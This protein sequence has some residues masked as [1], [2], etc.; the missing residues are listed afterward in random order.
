MI[1]RRV[2]H[3]YSNSVVKKIDQGL[4]ATDEKYSYGNVRC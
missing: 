1:T 2:L 3:I 4:D